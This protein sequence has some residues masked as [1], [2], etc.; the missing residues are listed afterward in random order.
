MTDLPLPLPHPPPATNT[1]SP[2]PPPPPRKHRHSR[3]SPFREEPLSFRNSAGLALQ[4]IVTSK[5]TD[6]PPTPLRGGGGG[7]GGGGSVVSTPSG[8]P[9]SQSQSPTPR[10]Y[11][12]S[13][14]S[15][16]SSL[17]PPDPLP[18]LTHHHNPHTPLPS[19]P[20]LSPSSTSNSSPTPISSS[21]HSP[22]LTPPPPPPPRLIILCHGMAVS[23]SWGF[24]P[25]LSTSLLH[26]V[27]GVSAVLRF[28]FTGCGGSEGEF[29]YGGYARQVG[30]I[31]AAV[32]AMR[33]R[34]YQVWALVGHSMGGN[35]VLLYAS[36]HPGDIPQVVNISA[37][38]HMTRGLPFGADQLQALQALGYFMWRP[39]G[40][41][42]GVGGLEGLG[43]VRVT[44]QTMNERLTLDMDCVRRITARVL[45]VHGTADTT[46][47]VADAHRYAELIPHHTL[48]TLDDADHNYT[49]SHARLLMITTVCEWLSKGG[50]R[51]SLGSSPQL[52][53]V[54]LA[55]SMRT[56][57]GGGVGGGEG[58][59]GAGQGLGMMGVGWEGVRGMCPADC[60]STIVRVE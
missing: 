20:P 26:E 60:D 8:S 29:E 4:G 11:S 7:G 40:V 13:T 35:A 16:L 18:P 51:D 21:T 57:G 33:A 41:G 55:R 6:H 58:G 31:G 22:L 59:G 39:K 36:E 52:T 42:V 32:Q 14:P 43:E 12:P 49:T 3:E 23:S 47:P 10:S 56:R 50:G 2:L 17:L 28:D 25:S 54:S 46:I 48:R 24:L 44:Q 45:T 5:P 15:L 34:G 19:T 1:T 9:P 37:R 30:D 53:P 38:Y 27:P